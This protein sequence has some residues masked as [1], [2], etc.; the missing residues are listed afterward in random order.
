M[1]MTQLVDTVCVVFEWEFIVHMYGN[2][3]DFNRNIRNAWIKANLHHYLTVE[4]KAYLK[5]IAYL[6][7]F[8]SN[9]V[10]SWLNF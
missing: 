10:I 8:R 4:N 6:G 2:K 5:S 9:T 7:S 3:N 1:Y